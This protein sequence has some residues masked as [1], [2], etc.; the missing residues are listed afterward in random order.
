LGG[1]ARPRRDV[2]KAKPLEKLSDIALVIIDAEPPDDDALK[3]DPA[4]PHDAVDFPVGAHL[5]DLGEFSQLNPRQNAASGRSSNCR[6][7][8]RALL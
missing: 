7:G 8:P 1:A 5:D 6:G 4:P 3:I 2:G